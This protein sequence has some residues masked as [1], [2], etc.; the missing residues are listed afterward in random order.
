[1]NPWLLTATVLFVLM[2]CPLIA[3]S[4]GN[5]VGRLVGLETGGTM[6]VAILLLLSVGLDQDFLADLALA[7]AFLAFGGALV[8]TRF[9][10]RWF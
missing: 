4:R 3:C 1:M 9:L 8:F 7:L 6:A 10:E 5:T 2:I